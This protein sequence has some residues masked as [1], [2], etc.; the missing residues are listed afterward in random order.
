MFARA[1]ALLAWLACVLALVNQAT[2]QPPPPA[3]P[4]FPTAAMKRQCP[5]TAADFQ[6][7]APNLPTSNPACH[8]RSAEDP[9]CEP[10][11]CF[12]GQTNPVTH[13]PQGG[14][15]GT[16]ENGHVSGG[17]RTRLDDLPCVAV[18]KAEQGLG[19]V[20]SRTNSATSTL[21][22]AKSASQGT[23][24]SPWMRVTS[25]RRPA[26]RMVSKGSAPPL[27]WLAPS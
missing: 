2:A 13:E 18:R 1:P 14:C 5:R 10:P 25:W 21:E 12:R 16:D 27:G 22:S 17:E 6:F 7:M 20:R 11:P 26:P 23:A 4:N 24:A 19:V 3:V 8:P 15:H 9:Y